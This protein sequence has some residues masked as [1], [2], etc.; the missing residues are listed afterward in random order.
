MDPQPA[1][2]AAQPVTRADPAGRAGWMPGIPQ[3]AL[4]SV[5]AVSQW[6]MRVA[7]GQLHGR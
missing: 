4:L 2:P 3:C 6:L 1:N 5:P 7:Q